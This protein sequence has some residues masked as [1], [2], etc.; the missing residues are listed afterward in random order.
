MTFIAGISKKVISISLLFIN[1]LQPLKSADLEKINRSENNTETKLSNLKRSNKSELLLVSNSKQ[2]NEIVIQSDKQSEIND[3]IYAEGNVSLSYRGK[4][5]QADNLT[6]DKLNKKI[7]AKGN[8]VLILGDQI[9]KVS[10]LEYSFISEKGYLLDV[11]G[12]INTNTLMDDLSSN[13]SF[14]DANKIESLLKLEKEEALNTPGQINNWI[15]STERISIDGK[16]WK[17]NKAI[18]SNDILQSKQVKIEINSL[19]AYSSNEELRFRSSLNYLVLDENVSIPFWFGNRTL[20]KS[21]QNLDSKSSWTIGYDNLD[22]DG[23]FIGKKFNSLNLSDD[24]II[25]LEPQFLIQ[26]SFNGI[27]NSFVK[28]G[29]LITGEKVERDAKFADYFGFKSEI[30]GKVN[31]WDLEIVNEINSLDTNKFSDALRSKSI[32]NKQINFLNAKW[33]K[34]FYGV[35][36]D[37]VWNGSLGESEIYAGYGSKLEKKH[38]W[39]VNGTN[40]T[41]VFSLGLAHLKG[42][43]LGSKSL[44]NSVKGNLFYSLDQNIPLSVDKP[45]NKIINSSYEYIY[46]PIKK[47]LSLNTRLAGMYSLYHDGNHQEYI[48]FGFGP[49]LILGNFKTK[50]F[51]YTR[52]SILPF[53]KFNNGDSIFKFDQISDK[54]TLDIGFDQQLFGPILLKSN[55][56]LNLDSDSNDYGQFINSK[57]SINWKK[58]SY[59]FGIF[60]QPHIQAGGISFNLF[61]FK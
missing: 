11:Q 57:I 12:S 50:T 56:T 40:K 28:K 1:L 25:N 15:F 14:S 55:G 10:K 51:D 9:F 31:N 18:F 38:T 42:E 20:P 35:Y 21:G 2:L 16:K 33:D 46:E 27:T 36:R 53:Y 8:I 26:R 44:V 5:L 47:G 30:K 43:A 54:F 39:E 41:E 19:E 32:L 13:F 61:G 4:L 22:K 60:Y 23:L 59:E 24:F 6:Y 7:S 45:K 49:E 29:D 34:S 3:V 48:G 17:S 37:R 52:I 58:R